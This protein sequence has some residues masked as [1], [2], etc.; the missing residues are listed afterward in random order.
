MKLPNLF[1]FFHFL[2]KSKTKNKLIF[3]GIA[4]FIIVFIIKPVNVSVA[5]ILGGILLAF[6]FILWIIYAI[7]ALIFG[8]EKPWDWFIGLGESKTKNQNV[9]NNQLPRDVIS[10]GV[11]RKGGRYYLRRS[12]NGNIY[13]SYY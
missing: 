1:D 12:K 11:G 4:S 9:I 13:R 7:I 10:S 3:I 6:C 5:I 2:F 8:N